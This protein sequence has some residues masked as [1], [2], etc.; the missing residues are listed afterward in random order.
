MF[1]GADKHPS[2]FEKDTPILKIFYNQIPT[3]T[4]LAKPE[5]FTPSSN[6]RA[7]VSPPLARSRKWTALRLNCKNTNRVK[8]VVRREAVCGADL[9]R[10]GK[11]NFT[12]VRVKFKTRRE[13]ELD[14]IRKSLN[15][16]NSAFSMVSI[17]CSLVTRFHQIFFKTSYKINYARNCIYV[18]FSKNLYFQNASA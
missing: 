3:E 14:K 11:K 4:K 16:K 9:R 12:R 8:W 15:T 17:S 10:M 5:R 7:T 13:R 1:S 2:L 6:K 18:N